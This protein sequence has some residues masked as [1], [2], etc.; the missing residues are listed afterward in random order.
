MKRQ[1]QVWQLAWVL[2]LWPLLAWGQPGWLDQGSPGPLARQAVALLTDAAS[3]GLDP[4]DYGS[5]Q[6]QQALD[7]QPPPHLLPA[8]LDAAMQR[9]LLHLRFGRVDP[10]RVHQRFEPPARTG[11]DAALVLQEA[12][13]AGNVSLAMARAVPPLPVYESLRTA[14]LRYRQ[15]TD[16]PA[17]AKAL[18]A[19][20]AAARPGA[21][22]KLT[23]GQTWAGVPMLAQRLL[24]LGDLPAPHEGDVYAAEL[25]AAVQVFQ[26]RHGLAEDGEIGR[27]TLA[28]LQVTP[29]QRVRQI[30]LTL[31]R[32]RWTPLLQGPRMVVINVPEFVLRAYEVQDGRIQ[33]KLTMR[34]IVGRSRSN[35]TPLFSEPMRSIEFSPFWNVPSSIARA[36]LVP[37]LRSQ[38][39]HFDA[40][41]F[42]F[43]TA[44]GQVDRQLSPQRLDDVLAGRA[45]LRQRPGPQN[46]LG[47]IKFVFPNNDAI[48]LHHT[49]SVGL[50]AQDRRDLSHGCI[51]VQDPVALASFVLARQPDW[52]ETRIRQAM[53]A[54][55]SNT[56]RLQEPLPV[57]IAY[58]T[59]IVS[60]GEVRFFNDIY[61]YD[62]ALDQALRKRREALP[63]TL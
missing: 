30:A 20:P 53:S 11:F 33:V 39:G 9:Y 16:D 54:G 28:A 8:A 23:L 51:R 59:A 44:G 3:H 12:M 15:W 52:D 38:P 43:V 17:W 26:R 29:A 27:A 13:A 25:V 19:L 58:G 21:P 5:A 22:A 50:F 42:E 41:G 2:W 24:R 48:Y 49:P 61:G 45:R 36:E 46:A 55:T 63:F 56:L 47:D 32:L 40:A 4:A 34:V 6:L 14:L 1:K 7:A 60:Q 31:E 10:R 57:L 62:A 35:R 37:R 18:P